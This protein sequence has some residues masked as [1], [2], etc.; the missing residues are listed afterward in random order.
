MEILVTNARSTVL[1][2]YSTF[3]FGP[4]I[5]GGEMRFIEGDVYVQGVCIGF[6]RVEDL[7]RSARIGNVM[8]HNSLHWPGIWKI[9]ASTFLWC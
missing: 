4:A 8:V 1:I 3:D 7:S 6:V 2:K 9:F 5:L